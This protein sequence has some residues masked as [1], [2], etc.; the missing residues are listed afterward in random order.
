MEKE[1]FTMFKLLLIIITLWICVSTKP[2][3]ENDDHVMN[4]DEFAKTVH[5]MKAVVVK[6]VKEKHPDMKRGEQEKVVNGLMKKLRRKIL[7]VFKKK[8][9]WSP[10]KGK[11]DTYARML[12]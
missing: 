10:W 9:T 2:L 5:N 12:R 7:K 3:V 11:D 4:K 8:L 1:R 6:Y